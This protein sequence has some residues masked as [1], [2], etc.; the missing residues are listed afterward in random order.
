MSTT[1]PWRTIATVTAASQDRLRAETVVLADGGTISVAQKEQLFGVADRPVWM[2]D[3]ADAV[4]G[5]V[6]AR[7]QEYRRQGWSVSG[8]RRPIEPSRIGRR[9]ESLE[10]ETVDWLSEQFRFGERD[11]NCLLNGVGALNWWDDDRGPW[12]TAKPNELV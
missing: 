2:L 4:L 12:Q 6:P 11:L 7:I 10:G 5:S 3:L 8:I 9:S 1:G